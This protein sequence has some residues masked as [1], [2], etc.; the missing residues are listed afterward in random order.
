ME[1]KIST[2]EALQQGQK[3]ITIPT[4][5]TMFGLMIIFFVLGD[6]GLIPNQL[7]VLGLLFSI[8]CSWIVWSLQVP[9]WKVWAYGRVKDIGELK[10][11]AVESKLIWNDNSIFTRTEI[12]T[13]K[14][15]LIIQKLD[16]QK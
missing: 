6:S 14:Q 8:F 16:S 1:N 11:S 3:I 2:E 10:S 5:I 15:K 9:K 13:K 7:S 4:M 12:W